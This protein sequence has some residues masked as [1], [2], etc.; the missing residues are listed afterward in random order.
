[1]RYLTIIGGLLLAA[2]ASHPPA[3]TDVPASQSLRTA[4]AA[5]DSVQ[6]QQDSAVREAIK[7][8]Y[9][10][11]GTD[12]DKLYCREQT[13]IGSHFTDTACFTPDQLV[14]L[15]AVQSQLQDMLNVPERCSG[16]FMCNGRPP[17]GGKQ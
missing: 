3:Q 10:A 14:Q 5:P 2:C 17:T 13:H 6:V 4:A 8:G 12:G 1:M 7:T 11:R 16:G 15:M 9:R